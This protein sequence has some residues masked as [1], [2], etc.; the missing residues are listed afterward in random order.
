M[1]KTFFTFFIFY[2]K[3]FFNVFLFFERFLFLVAKLFILL[4]LQNSEKK[5]LLSDEFN[6]VAVGNSLTKITVRPRQ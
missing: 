6:T 1:Q 2:K 5:R 4:N 3:A